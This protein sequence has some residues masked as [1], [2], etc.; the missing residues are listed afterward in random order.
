MDR[1]KPFQSKLNPYADEIF[2]WLDIH[3]KSYREVAALLSAKYGFSVTHNA[4]FSFATRRRKRTRPKVYYDEIPFNFQDMILRQITAEWTYSSTAIEGNTFT[5]GDTIKA[6]DYGMEIRGKMVCE[7][8]EIYGHAT[9]IDLVYRMLDKPLITEQDVFDLHRAVMPSDV[10]VDIFNPVGAWKREPNGTYGTLHGHP[11]YMAYAEPDA[12]PEL[13]R[14]W[15]DDLNRATR[16]IRSLEDALTASLM[17]HTG[18]VR[19]HPFFDGNGRLARLLANIPVLC[20]GYPPILIEPQQRDTYISLLWRYQNA[21]GQITPGT[22]LAPDHAEL[23][24][25]KTLLRNQWDST[26]KLV[27]TV[28]SGGAR[29]RYKGKCP[30]KTSPSM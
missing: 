7:Q 26:L 18:F 14:R 24:T 10:A 29:F 8:Q 12:V 4:V 28:K 2:E 20:A 1:S 25:F 27:E 19:I 21:V 9:A 3:E 23:D 17:A 22:P 30:V 13:M 5:L 11:V 16:R 15:L 6:L